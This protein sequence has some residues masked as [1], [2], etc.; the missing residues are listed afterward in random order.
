M[1]VDNAV[2]RR[3]TGGKQ[4]FPAQRRALERLHIKYRL[5]DN[6]EPLVRPEDL[7][8]KHKPVKQ[9]KEPRWGDWE[10]NFAA[11]RKGLPAPA[12]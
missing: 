9:R 1:Y 3:L 10:N 8:P 4:R 12:S 6:G 11:Q 2:V 5:A 7:D